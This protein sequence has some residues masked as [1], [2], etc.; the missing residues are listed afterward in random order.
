MP[1][2]EQD[3]AAKSYGHGTSDYYTMYNF[4]RKI[5]GCADADIIDVYEALDM[6]LPGLFAYRSVLNG[7]I[8]MDIPNLRDK[9]VRD[10]YRNDTICSD[11]KVAGDQLVPSFSKGNP[12]IDDAV[13][14]DVKRKWEQKKKEMNNR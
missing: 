3:E 14:E 4:V 1:V 11:P 10:Q 2:R 12:I 7:G 5:Q 8:P 9:A 6:F 13:Y